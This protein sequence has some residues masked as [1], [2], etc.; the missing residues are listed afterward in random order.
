MSSI[1]LTGKHSQELAKIVAGNQ[2]LMTDNVKP[3]L[4]TTLQQIK[5]I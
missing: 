1:L 2:F 4:Q 5:Y 3:T